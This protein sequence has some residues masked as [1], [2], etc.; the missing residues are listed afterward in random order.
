M[1]KQIKYGI[2]L[3]VSVCSLTIQAQE[4]DTL[5]VLFV[6]NSYTYFWNLPQTISAMATNMDIHILARKS[7]AGGSTLKQHWQGDKN[8]NT[9]ELIES[10]KWDVV[11]LQDHSMI[12]IEQEDD[13]IEYTSKFISL[14]KSQGAIPILYMTWAR[15]SNPLM[16]EQISKSYRSLG[17]KNNVK[18]AAVGEVWEK[19][20]QLMP[21]FRLYDPDGSH[22]STIGTYLTALVFL[23]ILTG[24]EVA[25]V[26]KRISTTDK[27]GEDLFYS[28]MS[29]DDASF[30]QQVV[31]S[32]DLE[33]LGSK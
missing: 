2:L 5:K 14:V 15:E 24:K 30:M 25:N 12:T 21:G 20:R 32:T 3:L 16:Q 28:I 1:I 33:T 8:L 18:V 4:K 17:I 29:Q 23:K 27:N 22:P 7:T 31:D 13:F 9:I 6:G 11:V 19:A 10:N 26:P